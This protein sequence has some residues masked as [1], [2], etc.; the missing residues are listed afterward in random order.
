MRASREIAWHERDE[1]GALAEHVPGQARPL[2]HHCVEVADVEVA[3]V[4]VADV[5]VADVEVADVQGVS[6]K[7]IAPSIKFFDTIV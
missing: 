4:E 5:E 7:C 1:H 6:P 2:L 3:D